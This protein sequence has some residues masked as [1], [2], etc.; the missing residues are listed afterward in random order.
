ML[1]AGLIM[2]G[3]LLTVGL[4]ALAA[5]AGK[6]LMS[7]MLALGMS[8]MSA[9][10]AP[11]RR[12]RRSDNNGCGNND[13]NDNYEII[14]RPVITHGHTHSA[15]LHHDPGVGVPTYP[16]YVRS[17]VQ[18]PPEHMQAFQAGPSTTVD[19]TDFARSGATRLGPADSSA[20]GEDEAR[21]AAAAAR[22]RV[23]RGQEH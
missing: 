15:V 2:G 14:A 20:D 18:T 10:R 7:A 19:V 1:G 9:L 4:G 23:R 22:P 12:C 13:G 3:T 17:L 21:G 11:P 16:G 8:L 5:M 6:A